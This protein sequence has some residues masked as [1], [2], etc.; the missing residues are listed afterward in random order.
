MTAGYHLIG[1]YRL[2][3]QR[4]L[5]RIGPL[6]S[7]A[8]VVLIASLSAFAF[9]VVVGPWF[10]RNPKVIFALVVFFAIPNLGT[11]WMLYTS[12]RHEQNPWPFVALSLI[13]YSFIWYYFERARP[14]KP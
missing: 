13:P 3:V 12:V 11:L 1:D 14:G 2:A 4:D 10:P 9:W 6:K 8:W 5:R 7:L